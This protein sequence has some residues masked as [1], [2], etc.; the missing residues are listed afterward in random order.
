MSIKLKVGELPEKKRLDIYIKENV[1]DLTREKIKKMI[2]ENNIKVNDKISKANYIV[3]SED[4]IEINIVEEI[5]EEKK[6]EEILP[7]NIEL[8]IIYED[9]YIAVIN[10][11]Q[12]MVVH[13]GA[14]NYSG[15]LVNA[16]IYKYKELS[17]YGGEDRP[18]IVHR[19]DKETSGI[20]V[21]AKNNEVHKKLSDMFKN[22]EIKRI[23][24]GLSE[25]V[26]KENRGIIET[27]IGRHKKD[28]KRMEVKEDGEGKKAVTHFKV[29]KRFRENTLFE[30]SLQTGRTHQIRV[31]FKYIGFPIVGDLTYGYKN[32]RYKLQG[33]LLHSKRVE[34]I[35]PF[36]N[37]KMI[38]VAKTPKYFKDIL[39]KLNNKE[40]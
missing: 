12:G 4:E 30:A 17:D 31:H 27:D 8:D 14:G 25:R 32:Q 1:K 6:E 7:E 22:N 5:I 39:I 10:K 9:D 11:P 38:L 36:T 33:Q 3:K 29:L 21:I 24:I 35:H 16:L 26:I 15:T 18:G 19:L 2:K 20:L 13:P 40:R 23:Y 34:F 28:R 37:K